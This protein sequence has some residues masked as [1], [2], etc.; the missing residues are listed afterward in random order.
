MAFPAVGVVPPALA[1][2]QFSYNGFVFGPNTALELSKLEGLDLPNVRSGDQGR[3]RDH[4]LFIGLDLLAGREVT[5]TGELLTVNPTAWPSF[6]GATVPGGVTET[7]LFVNLP[8]FGTLALMARVRKRSAPIDITA[9]LGNLVSVSLMFSASDPRLYATPT[10]SATTQPPGTTAGF[11]FP[12]TFPVSFGGGVVSGSLSINNAGDIE[13]RPILTVTGPC[14]NPS[15]TNATAPGSP[16][17]TFNVSLNT[18]D[19]LVID[20][21][22]HTATFYAA[23]STIGSTRLYTLARGSTWFTLPPGFNTLQFLSGDPTATGSLTCVW[24]SAYIL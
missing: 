11:T 24:A 16:N 20:T 12:L 5:L 13:T 21:D 1:P 23:G 15:I 22:F 4:G 19:T 2:Y 14:T 6:A 18:G 10:Q 17:L 7:P 3:A 9:A 8:A